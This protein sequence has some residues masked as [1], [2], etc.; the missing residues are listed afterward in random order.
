MPPNPFSMG[1]QSSGQAFTRRIR[2]GGQSATFARDVTGDWS[3]AI[4]DM[5]GISARM[6][7]IG[8]DSAI[9]LSD[10]LVWR[11]KEV[12][13]SM[14]PRQ[15]TR[16]GQGTGEAFE[17]SQGRLAA[18]W[19]EYTPEDMAGMNDWATGDSLQTLHERWAAANGVTRGGGE[20]SSIGEETR[21][22]MGALLDIKRNRASAWTVDVGTFLP[23][24]ALAN[25]GGT[26]MIHPYGNPNQTVQAVWEGVH[27]VELGVAAAEGAAENIIADG[28]GAALRGTAGYKSRRNRG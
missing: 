11:T 10:H 6:A 1:Q 19:G 27:F 7:V 22:Q 3:G 17:W 23:Y 25:D 12:I 13:R 16:P 20:G 26:M 9:A 21:V 24:A 8:R 18:A 28:V 4:E 15:N 2:P 14:M 5:A